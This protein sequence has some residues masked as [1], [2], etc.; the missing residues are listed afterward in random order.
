MPWMRF[1][2]TKHNG[3]TDMNSHQELGGR[4]WKIFGPETD[5][6]KEQQALVTLCYELAEYVPQS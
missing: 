4:I 3:S 5:T 6:G 2:Y 1:L